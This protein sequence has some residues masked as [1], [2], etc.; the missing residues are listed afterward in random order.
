[1]KKIVT[2]APCGK[3]YTMVGRLGFFQSE[4]D[5]HSVLKA[6]KSWRKISGFFIN[7]RWGCLWVRFRRFG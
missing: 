7:T 4:K 6:E 3:R 5:G 2:I 1:M